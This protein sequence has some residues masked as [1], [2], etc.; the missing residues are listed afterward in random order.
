MQ[1]LQY[2]AVK[3]HSLPTDEGYDIGVTKGDAVCL[4]D[5][6]LADAQLGNTWFNSYIVGGGR[7]N[8]DAQNWK[9]N[10]AKN[11]V[12]RYDDEPDNFTERV[13][14]NVSLTW[15]SNSRFYDSHNKTTD[16]ERMNA[17]LGD[18]ENSGYWYLVPVEFDYKIKE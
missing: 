8:S 9:T 4:L 7:W 16:P 1:T 17:E 11:D 13:V 14:G 3:T 10:R 5:E 18:S 2:I 15:D 12:I 6:L